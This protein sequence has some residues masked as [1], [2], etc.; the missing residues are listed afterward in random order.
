MGADILAED[1]VS[2]AWVARRWKIDRGTVNRYIQSGYLKAYRLNEKGWWRILKS[3]VVE[4]EKR[5]RA[6]Q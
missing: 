3:S 6:S 5:V 1:T 2:V 4:I